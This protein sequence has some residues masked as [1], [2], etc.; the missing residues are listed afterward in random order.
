MTFPS[1]VHDNRGNKIP[2]PPKPKID[3]LKGDNFC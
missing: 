3:K 1:N 2:P